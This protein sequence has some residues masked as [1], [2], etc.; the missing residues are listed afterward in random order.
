MIHNI[1][2]V[3][4]TSRNEAHYVNQGP[5]LIVKV[6]KHAGNFVHQWII[7]TLLQQHSHQAGCGLR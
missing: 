7:S 1:C 2:Q 6:Q 5:S 3:P 4:D